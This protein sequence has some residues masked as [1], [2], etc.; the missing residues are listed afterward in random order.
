M[1][2]KEVKVQ[3]TEADIQ[4]ES[5]QTRRR[6]TRK[7]QGGAEEPSAP[8]VVQQTPVTPQPVPAAT[9]ATPTTPDT[10]AVTPAIP[11]TPT[12]PQVVLAPSSG[13][14]AGASASAASNSVHFKT[15]KRT[16]G[17]AILPTPAPSKS[18][19]GA[20]IL[21]IK[22]HAPPSKDKPKLRIPVG[23]QASG[24]ASG[25]AQVPSDAV[26]ATHVTPA[27]PTTPVATPPVTATQT[28]AIKPI[29][30]AA[31]P[32]AAAQAGGVRRR[33]KFT[34]R[35]IG[36]SMKSLKKTRK[37]SKSIRK[38]VAAMPIADIRKVLTEK[39]ILKGGKRTPEP[40]L[41]S[42]MTDYLSLKK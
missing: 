17:S 27:T 15:R 25:Q 30:A 37:S 2:V 11:T 34:E 7:V 33:R 39:G 29:S 35:R 3:L 41:R 32:T 40:M 42:L 4:A 14:G 20:R 13:G 26:T 10:P 23:G 5:R 1:T 16:H 22:R 6:R 28:D 18:I 36:I 19:V 12:P 38:Q 9:L 31:A 21:P 24:Q 8:V